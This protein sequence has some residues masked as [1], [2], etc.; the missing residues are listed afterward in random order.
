MSVIGQGGIFAVSHLQEHKRLG[1]K[2][3]V[4]E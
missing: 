4:L 1:V 3:G 2:V